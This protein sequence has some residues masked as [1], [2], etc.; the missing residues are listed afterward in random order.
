M[1]PTEFLRLVLPSKGNIVIATAQAH[2]SGGTYYRFKKF[3][4]PDAASAYAQ[5]CDAAGTTTYFGVNSFGDWYHDETKNKK[6]IRTATN[7]VA[8]RSLF[9]DFDVDPT[10]SEAYATRAEAGAD[11]KR[12]A[13]AVRLMPT[14]VSSGGGFHA[15]IHLDADI[16]PDQWRMLSGLKRDITT[17]L[18]LKVDA[19][20][21]TDIARILRPVGTH[22]RKTDT[23]RE[24]TV[25]AQGGVY[26]FD[27]L[28]HA[29]MTY[30][31]THNVPIALADTSS[32][33]SAGG[34]TA[35]VF[36]AALT[37]IRAPSNASLVVERCSAI[38]EFHD[39]DGNVAEPHWHRSIGVLKFCE[40][41]EALIHEWSRGYDG[42]SVG[43]TQRK[44]N[45]WAVGPTSCVEMDKI[46]GCK[47]DCPYA[48]SCKFP[49]Q[50]GITDA[51]A[52]PPADD[53]GD[54]DEDE[55]D[56]TSTVRVTTK[57]I[58]VAGHTIP[59]WPA[60]GYQWTGEFI[61]KAVKNSDGIWDWRDICSSFIYPINR[62]QNLDGEWQIHWRARDKS[63]R[64]KEF[65][66]PTLELAAPDIMA[67]TFAGREVFLARSK[68]SRDD[69]AGFS[70]TMVEALQRMR[71]ESTTYAQMGW[72]PNRDGFVLGTTLITRKA[73]Q[74]VLCDP[75]IPPDAAVDFG[76]S[77]TLD[78]W[79][80]G[81]DHLYN[82]PGGEPYQFA[83]CH[84]M[85]SALVEL[86]GSSNWHGIPLAMTGDGGTGKSTVCK[87]ACGFWGNPE[88]M[89]HQTGKDGSTLNAVIRRV[90]AMGSVPILMDEFSGRTS[91]ELTRTGYALANGRDKERL[92]GDGSFATTGVSWYKNSFVTSNDSITDQI[93]KLNAGYVVEATQLRFFEVPLEEGSK[94]RVFHDVTQTFADHHMDHVYGSPARPFLRFLI[95][96]NDWVRRQLLNLRAQYNP[97]SADEGR[98]R[99]YRDA[100]VTAYVAGKIAQKLNLISFDVGKM[101]KWA[102]A[103]II[104]MRDN[105]KS[106]N[107]PIGDHLAQFISHLQG[108][109]IITKHFLDGRQ[110]RGSNAH[111]V[112]APLEPLRHDAVGRVCTV[113]KLFYVTVAAVRTW[114]KER[115]LPPARLRDEMDRSGA[116]ELNAAGEAIHTVTIGSGSTVPSSQARCYRLAYDLM[117]NG[118]PALKVVSPTTTSVT[119]V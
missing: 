84:S 12:F 51:P 109:L 21:R 72:T 10:K 97:Q 19:A 6:R 101:K 65:F 33:G 74:E 13:Q 87:I 104:S 118:S 63:G 54:E 17:F 88:I 75:S 110:T 32:V 42:Y 55:D 31:D 85:G 48:K 107:T 61:Q 4:S 116:L 80:A 71:V 68:T 66:M 108:R 119:A 73:D 60:R 15:Y 52:D 36:A 111:L 45:E 98:E 1:D 25:L 43:E 2:S 79:V 62:V 35:N 115:D 49:H 117:F 86:M 39:M 100:V 46:I 82:R 3:S 14:V 26:S 16:T 18:H 105:R 9:D 23:P 53:A 24:V 77:G 20:V 103:H 27:C 114:C 89:E 90:A 58:V 76:V 81:I 112:E 59:H 113:D 91:E 93:A 38:R 22:N 7:V 28:Q 57:P 5:K 102:D 41:G 67:K 40:D 29:F 96:N 30:I 78:E 99:F 106:S 37:T 70:V 50:L 64:W 83:L 56:G 95:K 8:C 34:G 47:A 92:R 44:I 94:E 11:I 69:M